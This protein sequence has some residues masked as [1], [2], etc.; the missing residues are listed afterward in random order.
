MLG[1]EASASASAAAAAGTGGDTEGAVIGSPEQGKPGEEGGGNN[2]LYLTGWTRGALF[3]KVPGKPASWFFPGR[4]VRWWFLCWICV[5][6]CVWRPFFG[7]WAMHALSC[8][9]LFCSCGDS[10]LLRSRSGVQ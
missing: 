1:P 9:G 6:V 7:V 10:A 4:G 5:S 8:F 3:S 2:A